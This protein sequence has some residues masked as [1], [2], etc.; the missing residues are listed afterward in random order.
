MTWSTPKTNWES[1]DR[2]NISDYNRIKNNLEYLHEFANTLYL[3][4]SI[5]DMGENKESYADFFYADEF[6]LFEDNLKVINQT[7][8]TQ[9][10]G[11]AQRFYDNGQ[12]IKYDELNRIESAILSIY[13]MLN[14]QKAGLK[15][16]SFR[17]GDMKGVRV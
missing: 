6:N 13:E 17:L 7:V 9:D 5:A 1:T 14:R 10:I 8:F 16:L 12:F 2:F 3:S 11:Y 15:V 4:F